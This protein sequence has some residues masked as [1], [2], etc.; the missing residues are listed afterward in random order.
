MDTWKIPWPPGVTGSGNEV[1]G[2]EAWLCYT[3]TV[4]LGRSLSSGVRPIIC[5]VSHTHTSEL[6]LL[7]SHP[8][9]RP[10]DLSQLKYHLLREVFPDP[11]QL[12]S[13]PV[14]LLFEQ[15]FLWIGIYL[16][17]HYVSSHPICKL[18]EGRTCWPSHLPPSAWRAV[19]TYLGFLDL[20]LNYYH[21]LCCSGLDFSPSSQYR[22]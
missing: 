4:R 17:A 13:I 21:F 19:P 8:C 14:L 16:F 11:S 2:I 5:N 9:G 10:A 22:L 1:L 3:L 6:A 7:H 20:G 15:R 12:I 18:R